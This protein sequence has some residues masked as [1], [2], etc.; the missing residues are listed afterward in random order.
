M[1]NNLEILKKRIEENKNHYIGRN[2]ELE[3]L[4]K[5]I[6]QKRKEKEKLEKSNETLLL[7]K[8]LIEKSCSEARENGRELLSQISTSLVQSVFNENTEVKL[9][10]DTKDNIPTADV[11][12]LNHYEGGTNEVDP[13]DSDGGGLADIVALSLFVSAGQTLENNYAPY[14]IDE[15]SKYVSEGDFSEKF[16]KSFKPLVNYTGK[17]TIISTHDAFLIESGDTIYRIVKDF[18]TGI[19]TVTKENY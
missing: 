9:N 3:I 19:S 7:K 8:M 1:N 12:V 17:Q 4:N 14:I 10:I 5:T 2:G 15:P 16:S 6:S 18:T 13:T 11:V